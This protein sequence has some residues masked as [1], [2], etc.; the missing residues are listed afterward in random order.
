M[1]SCMNR[2]KIP[3]HTGLGIL[4]LKDGPGGQFTV[5][6]DKAIL[7]YEVFADHPWIHL[8]HVD[9]KRPEST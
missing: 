3:K 6:F 8:L 7:I 5:P 4:P 1:R 2:R 9:W